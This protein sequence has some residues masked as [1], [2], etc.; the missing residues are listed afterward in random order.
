MSTG[1]KW[2]K[3][4]LVLG[5]ARDVALVGTH[6][7]RIT[8][9]SWAAKHGSMDLPERSILGY[10]VP[11]DATS[12]VTYSRDA[13]AGPMAK[14]CKVLSDIRTGLFVPDVSRSGRFVHIT[15]KAKQSDSAEEFI[16]ID[17]DPY[18]GAQ[19]CK[20]KGAD[21]WQFVPEYLPEFAAG[22]EEDIPEVPPAESGSSSSSSSSS[23]SDMDQQAEE[24]F[25]RPV[26]KERVCTF[27]DM[28]DKVP[29]LHKLS[30]FLHC[31][32]N[33]DSKSKCG[34]ILTQSYKR[35]E[36]D[37]VAGSVNCVQCFGANKVPTQ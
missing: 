26:S 3:D 5:G 17:T 20:S 31:R 6:S 4:L 7:P 2:L 35:T 27:G 15:K 32:L 21:A 29:Y 37:S 11:P 28:K 33:A 25:D 8:A 10:H 13:L 24:V 30:G 22:E 19:D 23:D 9:L 36:W 14:F 1:G 12:A 18:G 16:Q 34:R